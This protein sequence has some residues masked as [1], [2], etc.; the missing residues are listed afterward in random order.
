MSLPANWRGISLMQHCSKLLNKLILLRLRPLIDPYLLCDQ[1]GFRPGRSTRE[2]A[3]AHRILVEDAEAH[4]LDLF[5]CYVDFSKA[6]D[7]PP[8]WAIRKALESWGVPEEITKAA[9]EMMQG[10]TVRLKGFDDAAPIE[11]KM[12]VLQGD[13]LAP[14]VF[15][16]LV[17]AI[18]RQLLPF[19]GVDGPCRD[20]SFPIRALAFADDVLLL[21]RSRRELQQMFL[22]FEK[23]ARRLGLHINLGKGK[24]E[25]FTVAP[26][27]P[28]R[29]YTSNGGF[30]PKVHAYKYLGCK[31]TDVE[32][33]WASVRGVSHVR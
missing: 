29:L 1:A 16:L 32:S 15:I 22:T 3:L 28:C 4:R 17:D 9:M 25:C 31:A 12:G 14:F 2:H 27:R 18:L 26:D 13:T 10:H 30:I 11:V 5:G 7:S 6:F 33:D 19:K 20:T 21:A 23:H 24:T 8:R